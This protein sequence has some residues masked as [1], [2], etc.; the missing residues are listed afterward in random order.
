MKLQ[1]PTLPPK[2]GLEPIAL[3]QLV[4]DRSFEHVSLADV[5]ASQQQ[6]KSLSIDTAMLEKVML[7]EATLEKIGLSDS[8]LRACDLSA[9]RCSEASFIR[10]RIIGSRLTGIDLSR[11]TIKD[12]V[13]ENCKLDMA[14]F[15]FAKLT[16][17]R[18]VNCALFETDFQ[19]AELSGVEFQD[20]QL[21]KVEFHHCKLR[22]VDARTSQLFDIR[23]WQSL[24]G[25]TIDTT[26]LVTVA[27]QLALELGL[28]IED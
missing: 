6:I 1:A 16:R 2:A 4:S 17:V 19:A 15:R 22:A 9:A 24:K 8:E 14:N 20:S 25:L 10:V 3:A 21:E 23:G 28:T 27:P 11:S 12:V 7:Y 18:F 26:Q 13:F 5:D